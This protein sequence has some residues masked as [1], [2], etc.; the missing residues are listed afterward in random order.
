MINV[1]NLEDNFNE[2]IDPKQNNFFIRSIKTEISKTTVKNDELSDNFYINTTEV[3]SQNKQDMNLYTKKANPPKIKPNIRSLSMGS[4]R[5]P[6][7]YLKKPSKN[8]A[9]A[10]NKRL[11]ILLNRNT[12]MLFISCINCNNLI[13]VD[14]VGI[15]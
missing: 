13:Q 2:T 3:P 5:K 6:V 1:D 11:K 4:E 10:M 7:S 14:S 12:S 15:N 9:D 8:N